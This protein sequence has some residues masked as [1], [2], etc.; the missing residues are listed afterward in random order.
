MRKYFTHVKRN[1]SYDDLL[2]ENTS[3]GRAYV[4]PAG[5]R[6]PS[7]TTVLGILSEDSIRAWRK[8]VGEEE[9]NR[10]SRKAADRG[11]K[12]HLIAEKYL[13]NDEDH[14]AGQPFHVIELFNSIKPILDEKIDNVHAQEIAL[15]SD[16]FK[17]AGRVDCIAEFGG[18]LSV[19]DYKTS[20][21][22]KQVEWITSYFMQA[23]FYSAAY[24]EQTN[25]P[26]TQSVIVMAVEASEPQV[27]IQPTFP[28]LKKLLRVRNEYRTRKG[29]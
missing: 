29:F 5:M 11:T 13:D 9:A 22:P 16:Q 15:F 24:F 18:E 10:I 19:I 23:A 21:K 4:T 3:G 1:L 12:M 8:R 6:Y 25:I 14:L 17:I 28:W 26:I 2:V 7:I 27:F 20:S